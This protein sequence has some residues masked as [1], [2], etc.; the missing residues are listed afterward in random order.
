MKVKNNSE[1]NNDGHSA[2]V[3][4]VHFA[5]YRAELIPSS[6]QKIYVQ[7]PQR[8]ISAELHH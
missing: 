1:N 2:Y 3:G 8:P 4:L 5:M 6:N 7:L